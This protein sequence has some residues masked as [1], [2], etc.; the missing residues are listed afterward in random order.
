MTAFE[1]LFHLFQVLS[2]PLPFWCPAP[3]AA[4]VNPA[5]TLEK[6]KR[7]L[8][9]GQRSLCQRAKGEGESQVS[10]PKL[11]SCH[12]DRHGAEGILAQFPTVL[13]KNSV[14]VAWSRIVRIHTLLE[15]KA[16]MHLALL[17]LQ[18]TGGWLGSWPVL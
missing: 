5:K 10:R 7:E 6:E 11:V 8:H 3:S 13:P 16:P 12:T 15:C 2:L 14:A 1:H 9:W 18:F 4:A 17:W